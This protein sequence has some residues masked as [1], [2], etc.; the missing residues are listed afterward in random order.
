MGVIL[1]LVL[2]RV[3]LSS[4]ATKA[5]QNMPEHTVRKLQ[6]W[7]DDVEESGLDEVRRRSGWHDE[8]LQGQHQQEVSKHEY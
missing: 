1:C 5:L 2:H 7:V 8:P 4:R 3:K 6:K